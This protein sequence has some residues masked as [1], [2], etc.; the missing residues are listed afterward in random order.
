MRVRALTLIL[1]GLL[2]L[3]AGA[4]GGCEGGDGGDADGGVI[5]CGADADCAGETE[6]RACRDRRCVNPCP[7]GMSYVG[8]G[9]YTMGCDASENTEMMPR[10]CQAD[11]QP[12]HAVKLSQS[13]CIARTELSVGQYRACAAAGQCPAPADLACSPD[14]TWRPQGDKERDALPMTCLY[15]A[16]ARAACGHAY[17]DGRLPTEAEWE[18]AARGGDGRRYPWGTDPPKECSKGV[19]WAAGADCRA[20][21]WAV[22]SQAGVQAMSA[23]RTLDMAGNVWEWVADW[24]SPRAYPGCGQ[25]CTDPTGPSEGINRVRRGGSFRS[26][27]AFELRATYREFHLPD[28]AR[29][30]MIGARCARS[31]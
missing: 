7:A 17:P 18:A 13:F 6:K 31:L 2:I 3:S 4:L 5:R 12:T 21:P 27:D 14:A 9:E 20:T 11:S 10:N 22:G 28:M 19:N 25:G 8:A 15:H 23:A 29:S 16:E 30:D 1:G 24:Y 26:K